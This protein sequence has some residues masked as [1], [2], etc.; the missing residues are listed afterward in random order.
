VV[1]ILKVKSRLFRALMLT[2]AAASFSLSMSFMA[3][4]EDTASGASPSP[5]GAAAQKSSPPPVGAPRPFKMPQAEEYQMASG[6]NVQLIEDRRSPFITFGLGIKSGASQEPGEKRG[7]SDITAGMLSEGT[8]SKTSKQ[9]A[10]EID[11]IG[12]GMNAGSDADF[13]L[14]SGSALSQYKDRL[15]TVLA[16]TILNPTFPEEELKLQK[17]NITQGIISKRSDPGFLMEERFNKVVFGEHPYATVLPKPEHIAAITRDD[18]VNWHKQ[19]FLPN[20]AYLVVVGDFKSA[21]MKALLDK[22]FEGWKPGKLNHAADNA[23]PKLSGKRIYLV[24]RPGSVQSNI[25]VGNVGIKRTDPDYFPLLVA[26]QILGGGGNARLFLNLR[27]QKG[28][29]YGAYSGFAARR[30]PGAVYASTDVRTE[31]TGPALKEVF[32]ELE[33]IR[34]GEVSD[35]ELKNAKS[36]LV[37]SYQLGLETQGSITQRLLDA[38]MYNLPKDYLEKYSDNV[39]KVTAQDVQR[40]ARSHMDL[41]NATITVVGD[42][43]KICDE[44]TPFAPIEMYDI[45]GK[46]VTSPLQ[47]KQHGDAGG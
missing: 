40:V 37:G 14:I 32:L 4:A 1:A 38:K 36:Y 7:L 26:N 23:V 41:E 17:T 11:F 15:F 33:K 25:K 8:K 21:E 47:E 42:A 34:G 31:V 27:E 2:A 19:H 13:T 18:L 16:D 35:K 20:E 24:D 6:L 45:H 30:E 39:L 10:E 28:Y 22:T 43:S 3:L 9:I 5:T 29:T 46:L 12:G 44:L